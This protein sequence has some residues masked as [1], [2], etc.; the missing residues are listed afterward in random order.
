M[1]NNDRFSR[2][3]PLV[4]LTTPSFPTWQTMAM[5]GLWIAA[6]AGVF[7]VL[8]WNT[9]GSHGPDFDPIWNAV[10]K[11][12]SGQPVYT[13]DYSTEDPHYLY[14]P[15]ATFLISPIGLLPGRDAARWIMLYLGALCIFAAI[16]LLVRSVTRQYRL[17]VFLAF[18]ALTCW[19]NE[20]VSSTL[21][22]TNINGFLFLLQVIFA[23]SCVEAIRT[24]ELLQEGKRRF[25][26]WNLSSFGNKHVLVA[27]I[28]LGFAMAIKPQFVAMA[29]VPFCAGQWALLVIAA[30]FIVV[31]FAIGWFTMSQPMDYVDRLLPYIS[32]ARGYNNGSINGMAIQLGW[33]DG[34]RITLTAVFLATVV[35]AVLA[36][37][38]WKSA[39]PIL[40]M[41]AT[42]GVLFCGVLMS[43]GLVQG[44]YCIW[45]FPLFATITLKQSPMHSVVMLVAA[46]CLMATPA[47]PEGVWSPLT[48][49]FQW[50]ASIAWLIIPLTVGIWALRTTAGKNQSDG[51]AGADSAHTARSQAAE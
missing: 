47:M 5:K 39:Q 34:I 15:G 3:Y 16:W 11:Y 29:V 50:R 2:F 17:P 21:A 22:I 32:Q 7:H 51:P 49:V 24:R 35:F 45:L 8:V 12:V 26:A 43:S 27:G 36:L 33:S 20:P 37:W 38:R 19:T 9:W 48:T 42:L 41:Y 6:L 40:W 31:T 25:W 30:L 14:S 18:I 46:W 10:E 23:L 44:Y 4:H 28:A 13:E 1:H